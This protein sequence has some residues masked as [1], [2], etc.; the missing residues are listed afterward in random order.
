MDKRGRGVECSIYDSREILWTY[1]DILWTYQLLSNVSN[2]DEQ[3]PIR[4]DQYWGG[5]KFY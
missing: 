1:S 2:D 3:D 4:L 5:G